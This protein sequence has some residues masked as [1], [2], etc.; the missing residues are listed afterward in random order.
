MLT[1]K[2]QL[3]TTTA[4]GAHVYQCAPNTPLQEVYEALGHF[5][6]Y[7][8]GRLKELEEQQKAPV[9]APTEQPKG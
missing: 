9:E 5:R 4:G 1:N 3:E 6:T 8:Y 2:T 7:V